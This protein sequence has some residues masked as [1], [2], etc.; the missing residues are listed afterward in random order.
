MEIWIEAN[1]FVNEGKQREV[2]LGFI[3][4]LVQRLRS[5]FNIAAYHFLHQPNNR[6]QFR[7]LT[8]PD[9]VEKI[10]ELIDDAK[11]LE[12]VRD[13]KY[14]ETPY[15]GERQNFGEDG[16]NS[17][18]RLWEAGSDLALDLMDENIRKGPRFDLKSFVH[19][20]LNQTG[21]NWM[22]EANFHISAAIDRMLIIMVENQVKPLED[23]IAQLDERIRHL[24]RLYP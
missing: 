22:Q 12:Q 16:W 6:I 19:Y 5:E 14:P 23:K 11:K 7:V 4:P 15:P 1:I 10:K 24:E 17:T 9:K 21:L 13:V 3:K 8:T 18:Y 2:L 20:L